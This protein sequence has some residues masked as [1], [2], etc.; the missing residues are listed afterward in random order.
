MPQGREIFPR[1]T[2]E[3]NLIMGLATRPRGGS[4]PARIYELFPVLK[5]ML[6]RRG[7]DLW[8][9]SSNNWRSAGRWRCSRAC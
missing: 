9:A 2:V 6:R 4:I 3:E 5:S 1:L 8:Q 7:G